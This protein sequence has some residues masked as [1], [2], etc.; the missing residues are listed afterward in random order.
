MKM[1]GALLTAGSFFLT[2]AVVTN[3]WIQKKQFFPTVVYLTKS[4]PCMAVLY[5]QAFVF[6]LLLGKLMRKIF[7]GQLRA[8]E[9]EHLIERSW[10]AVTDTC[11]AFTM[12]RDDFSPR[13]VA[14]FTLLL[15]LKCFHWL[16]EDRVDYMERSPIITLLFK[17]RVLS[18]LALLSVLDVFF[19]NSSYETT[20]TKGASVQLVFGFEY[21]ILFTVVLTILMKYI[22]HMIDL[23]S[24]NP[25]ENKAVYMLYVELITGF[26]R[27][28]LYTCFTAIMIKIHT[29]PLFAIRPMYLT[30]RQFKKAVSDIILSRRAIRNMNTLYP[31]ATAEDLAAG[32]STCIICREEMQPPQ[33][34]V[35][36]GARQNAAG[37][38]KKLPCGHIFHASCLRSWFQRQ[39]TCPTCRLDVLQAVPSQTPNQTPPAAPQQPAAPNAPGAPPP[40]GPPPFGMFPHMFPPMPPPGMFPPPPGQEAPN[41]TGTPQSTSTTTTNN[42]QSSASGTAGAPPPPGS[43]ATGNPFMF[44]PPMMMPPFMP[45]PPMPPGDYSGMPDDYLRAMEGVERRA[46]EQRLECLRNIHS[47]LDAAMIQITQYVTVVRQQGLPGFGVPPV[48]DP[49]SA[50]SSGSTATTFTS[51]S[52]SNAPL[53]STSTISQSVA[54]SPGTSGTSQPTTTAADPVVDDVVEPDDTNELRRRRIAKLDSSKS[55][56]SM[57]NAP[58]KSASVPPKDETPTT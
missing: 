18:L 32:D 30:L 10:Y 37:I 2:G 40:P 47:L 49:A 8:A 48:F 23:Q 51:P 9:T 53:A 39:Q 22:L 14:S 3:A 50:S 12:F 42:G 33:E 44:M 27:V 58:E 34:Q 6:V 56:S 16:A 11:L 21:A 26:L 19:I 35:A 54:D 52:S 28:V 41:S 55:L 36:Q 25:W 13:F 24:E 5:I 45:P 17:A 43:G 29:F 46:V 1:R 57:D 4:S 20:I 38:I 15:F 31:D 7:F